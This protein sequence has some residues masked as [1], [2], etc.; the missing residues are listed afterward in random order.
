MWKK[1][2]E[3]RQTCNLIF[4]REDATFHTAQTIQQFFYYNH[5]TPLIPLSYSSDLA[6]APFYI[7]LRIKNVLIG[8]RFA[9]VKEV[10]HTHIHTRTWA[11]NDTN[12]PSSNS[13]LMS[14]KK[15]HLHK[16]TASKEE[17]F[18]GDIIN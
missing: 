7:F 6:C 10:K 18:E 4:R 9:D 16:W 17:Y 8:K 5:M 3:L 15:K 11:L 2:F 1:L 14:R 13:A 12:S